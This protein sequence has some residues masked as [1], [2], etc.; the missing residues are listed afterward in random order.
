MSYLGSRI[1]FLQFFYNHG[2]LTVTS[3][4]QWYTVDGGSKEYVKK[5]SESF[6][7]KINLG[8]NIVKS[9]KSGEK[10]IVTDEEG[11]DYEFDHVIFSTHAD[12]TYKIISD[13]SKYE[14]QI[15]SKIKSSKNTAIL[16]KDQ[17]QMP[18]SKKAWASWVY[19]SK[20]K[21]NK[22]SLSYWMNN[23]QNIEHSRP[24]F[25]TLNPID[26]ID[27]KDIF[28]KYEYE[29]PIFDQETIKAQENLDK[30]QGKRNIWFC[31]AWTKY[32]FHEDGLNS[33]INV[34]KQFEIAVPW[35]K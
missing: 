26:Q 6:S 2:L 14:E 24:L 20:K 1:R 29:H 12:Q 22:V 35:K 27:K 30:I 7:D 23:L 8:C 17:K 15:L 3:Q 11:K 31:G 33:A 19:L 28:G 13:K 21:E 32:G 9:K 16:H 18:K 10:I 34:A 25:V 4:P 5:M